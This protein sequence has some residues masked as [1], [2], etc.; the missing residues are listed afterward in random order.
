MEVGGVTLATKKAQREVVSRI[1]ALER[2]ERNCPQLDVVVASV[3][4]GEPGTKA[5]GPKN[6]S[7]GFIK[8]LWLVSACGAMNVY[9]VVLQADA[10]KTRVEAV[11]FVG[12]APRS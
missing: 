1:R 5:E 9:T 12:H 8:E 10:R 4:T 2:S 7:G 3:L 11:A 6:D